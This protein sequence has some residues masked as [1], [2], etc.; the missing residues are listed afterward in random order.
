MIKQTLSEDEVHNIL[1][2]L[3]E[4]NEAGRLD[5]LVDMKELLTPP[6]SVNPVLTYKV[7]DHGNVTTEEGDNVNHPFHYMREGAMECIDEM[8]TLFGIEEVKSFCKL[9]AWKYRYR[10]NEKN[11]LEDM[12]KSDW[13]IKKYRELM[14]H[15]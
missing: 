14:G 4:D 2:A 13:Y 5:G 7:K 9:N 1:N 3:I 11:G 12:K 10:A 15:E 8:V 6:K